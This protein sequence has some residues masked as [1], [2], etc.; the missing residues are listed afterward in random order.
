MRLRTAVR[1]DILAN[2]IIVKLHRFLLTASETN[3]G[4]SMLF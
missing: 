1:L 3:K 2:F 4:K